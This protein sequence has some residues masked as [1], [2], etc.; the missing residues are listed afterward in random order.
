MCMYVWAWFYV[1]NCESK[2]E[3]V[4]IITRTKVF[5]NRMH[6]VIHVWN[7]AEN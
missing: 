2:V 1:I 7:L 6:L 3:G 4:A 5:Y